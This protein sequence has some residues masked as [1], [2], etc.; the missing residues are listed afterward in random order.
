MNEHLTTYLLQNSNRNT[1]YQDKSTKREHRGAN[2][3]QSG[4]DHPESRIKQSFQCRQRNAD[5]VLAHLVQCPS[6]SPGP[7]L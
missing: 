3:N 2:V 7:A 6:P 4:H 1:T 5:S